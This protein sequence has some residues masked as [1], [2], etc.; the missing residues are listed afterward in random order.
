M[1]DRQRTTLMADWWPAACRAQ[2][3]KP[4]NKPLRLRALSV[5]VSF[6]AGH[7]RN[8]L[9]CLAV[10]NSAA[11]LKRT[12]ESANELDSTEDVDRVKAFCLMLADNPK[13][14]HEVDHPVACAM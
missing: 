8:V 10:I 13:A 9:E 14:A 2:G 12:L 5:A 3:W 11:P 7:F 1:T 6:P 4:S